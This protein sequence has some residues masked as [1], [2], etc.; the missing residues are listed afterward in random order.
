MSLQNFLAL[1]GV[2]DFHLYLLGAIFSVVSP[3]PNN[4]FLFF[5]TVKRGWQVGLAAIMGLLIGDS[6]L[7][8]CISFGMGSLL[9]SYAWLNDVLTFFSAS[10]LIWLGY[11]SIKQGYEEWSQT[12]PQEL[13][14]QPKKPNFKIAEK[15]PFL[16]GLFIALINPLGLL[17]YVAFFPQ[18]IA[19]NYARPDITL[20]FLS[21]VMLA[22][23]ILFFF[24]LIFFSYLMATRIAI[25]NWF[26]A[27]RHWPLVLEILSGLIFIAY[28]GR[29]LFH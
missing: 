15:G 23:E 27:H 20:S 2:I 12:L 17:F 11:R 26:Q 4:F 13:K 7:L 22:L 18:F 28:G 8:L 16:G 1:M 5:T 10:F 21:V 3:G 14:A 19:I 6:I 25:L 29:L 9:I 24:V